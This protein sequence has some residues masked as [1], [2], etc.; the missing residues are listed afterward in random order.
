MNTSRPINTL[1]D[2]FLSEADCI[3]SSKRTYRISLGLW[4]EW[5]VKHGDLKSPTRAH[6]LM[7]REYLSRNGKSVATI[8]LYFA[9]LKLLFKWLS[10]KDICNDIS[11]GI[12]W[13]KKS[14]VHKRDSL[15]IDQVSQLLSSMQ[16]VTL[17]QARNFAIVNLM[18]R[19]AL[20]CTEVSKLD[21]GDLIKKDG[22]YTLRLQRKGHKEKDESICITDSIIDPINKYLS[23]RGAHLPGDPMFARC[24]QCPGFRLST[25]TIGHVVTD[26]YSLIDIEGKT[27]SAHSLRHTA[28]E[29]AMDSGATIYEVQQLLGHRDLNTTMLYLSGF[30]RKG[31]EAANAI[32]AIDE[33]Y[34]SALKR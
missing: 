18:A 22:R 12:H 27:L 7:Y 33:L 9:V 29:C 6:L 13:R 28:A 4:V 5:M 14:I 34:R 20:R 21:V 17:I 31:R 3:E 16:S 24:G 30:D 8:S 19:A 26:A 32:N 1:L 15:S 10:S 25:I 23:L 11:I 2:E